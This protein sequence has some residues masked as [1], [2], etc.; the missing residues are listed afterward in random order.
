MTPTGIVIIGSTGMLGR[1]LVAACR[2]RGLEVRAFVGPDEI[3]ITDK[4]AVCL[5]VAREGPSVVINATG[6]TD[7][8]GAEAEPQAADQVN[9]VGPACL[10]R[11]CR[12]AGALLVH[13]STDY[14]FDGRSD[15]PYRPGDTPNPISVYGRSKFAGERE[16]TTAGCRYLLI[17]SSWLFAA[18]GRNFVRTILDLAA[19]HAE[20]N[21]VD[22]QCGRPTYAPDLAR[23]TLQLLDHGG[24]GTFHAANDGQGTWFELAGA[25]VE[26]A[27]LP[28]RV[29]PC[30][31]ADMPRPAARPR[32]SVLDLADTAALIGTLRPWKEA[33]A[34]CIQT[35]T[36]S[37]VTR[38][39]PDAAYGA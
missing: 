17:R 8:D 35:L 9:R 32:Y 18:H 29:R 31:S 6:Y 34:D 12:D 11:A 20:I 23:M 33:L 30:T 15:R 7:V 16:I 38:A 19:K 25:I 26:Q 27:G 24:H 22:D 3:D 36:R 37:G 13:Y 14:V 10:A 5:L 2:G 39:S 1:E 21:V 4:D 28:C